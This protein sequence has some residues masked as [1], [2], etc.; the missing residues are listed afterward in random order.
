MNERY[1]LM[2][3]ETLE[4]YFRHLNLDD[5]RK[6]YLENIKEGKQVDKETEEQYFKNGI[7]E[8]DS[9]ITEDRYSMYMKR[10]VIH[11]RAPLTRLSA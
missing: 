5:S 10:F 6:K 7:G 11:P 3:G 8:Q 4:D 2:S 1:Y 9:L